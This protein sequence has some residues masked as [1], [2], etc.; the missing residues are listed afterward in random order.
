[1]SAGG[2]EFPQM[3][4]RAGETRADRSHGHAECHGGFVVAEASPRAQGQR[5]LLLRLQPFHYLQDAVHLFLIGETADQVIRKVRL[6][7][8]AIKSANCGS[9]AAAAS[10]AVP[11]NIHRDPKQPG[12]AVAGPRHEANVLTA[13]PGDQ[14]DLRNDV[15]RLRPVSSPA[16]TEVVDRASMAVIQISERPPITFRY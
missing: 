11:Q 15:L 4:T 14:K 2:E 3:L 1:M 9:A 5:V 12:Q 16:E 10:R 13:P 7:S 8:V 6:R